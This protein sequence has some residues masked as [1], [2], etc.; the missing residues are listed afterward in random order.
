[1]YAICYRKAPKHYA[2][3]DIHRQHSTGMVDSLLK[4][5][6][7]RKSSTDYTTWLYENSVELHGDL[8][9]LVEVCKVD[10]LDN[11]LNTHPEL[12]I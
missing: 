9:G 7:F 1:M 11:L 3:F 2:I 10:S 12:F 8:D 5:L 4:P 6:S